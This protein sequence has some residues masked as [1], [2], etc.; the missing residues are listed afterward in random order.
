MRCGPVT[1]LLPCHSF[2]DFP[3]ALEEA[4]AEGL[5]AAW[6]GAWHP[7]V[8]A[9]VSSIPGQASVDLPPPAEAVVGVVPVC[10]DER[11]A[12]QADPADAARW[13]RG[14]GDAHA[15]TAA[16]AA[17]TGVDGTHGLPGDRHAAAFHSLGLAAL[18][19]ELLARRMRTEADLASTGFEAAVV[20]ASRAAVGGDDGA[21]RDGL[22][23]AYGCL[24]ATR[25]RYYSVESWAVDIVLLAAVSVGESL[26]RELA[27]PVP[28]TLIATPDAI[29]RLD[30]APVAT[31]AALRAA[32]AEGRAEACWGRD[33]SGPIDTCAPETIRDSLVRGR[34]AWQDAVGGPPACYAAVSGGCSAIL[35][36]LLE[37]CGCRVAIWSLFDGSSLP[38]PGCGRIRWEGTGGAEVEA[39]ARPPLDAGRAASIFELP[40]RIGETLDHDH[41][42]V[43]QFA[44]YAGRASRWHD[45]VRRIGAASNLLGTFCTPTALVDRTTGSGTPASFLPDAF[46]IAP[47]PTSATSGADPLAAAWA[48]IRDEAVT[49]AAAVGGVSGVIATPAATTVGPTPAAVPRRRWS[50]GLFGRRRDDDTL[51]LDNGLVELRPH[52]RSGGVLSLRRPSDRGNRISQQLAVRTTAPP[53]G[54]HW[55]SAEERARYGRM[56]VDSIVRIDAAVGGRIESRGRLLSDDGRPLG[57]FVQG[58]SLVPGMPL[59]VIDVEVDLDHA[60][61]GP[62]FETHV[63]CR[64]AWHENEDVE[65]RRSLHLQSVVTERRRFT[66]PHFIEVVPHGHRGLSGVNGLAIL[67]GGLPWHVSSSPHVI[68]SIV[69]AG[70]GSA[71]RRLAIGLGLERPWDA[72]VT[73]IAGGLPVGGPALPANVRLTGAATLAADPPGTVRFGLVESAGRTGE[74]RLALTRDVAGAVAVD[75]AGHPLPD[76]PVTVAGRE[77]VVFLRSYQW[78]HLAVRF[79]ESAAAGGGLRESP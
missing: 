36:Q 75:L 46:G 39:I 72:A 64:F 63:A 55:E 62:L 76:L 24:E 27:S 6:T 43:V 54:R 12:G 2:D 20:A 35:P 71:R 58:M 57:R 73:L 16:L 31:L 40:D 68:D 34:S 44:H 8:I 25:S 13:V 66:A 61:A 77:I 70:A 56:E 41:A 52:P 30:A 38:D 26:V 69:L 23:E 32:V 11:F 78:L 50:V 28:L 49:I 10:C 60:L 59:A 5:L 14:L 17:R 37:G 18:L 15:I 33:E 3:T 79:C 1:V 7:A 21:V 65:I 45:L 9:A 4:E 67:T 29:R 19:A 51:R 74:V 48:G 53:T 22:A 47:P 42:A